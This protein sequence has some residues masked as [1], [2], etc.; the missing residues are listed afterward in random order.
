MT[1]NIHCAFRG[2]RFS[3]MHSGGFRL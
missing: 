3:K 2:F 1:F